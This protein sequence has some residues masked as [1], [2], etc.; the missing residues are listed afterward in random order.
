VTKDSDA[1]AAGARQML[2]RNA[3]PEQLVL[4]IKVRDG[5]DFELIYTLLCQ[6]T[7]KK[8]NEVTIVFAM[9]EE[10]RRRARLSARFRRLTPRGILLSDVFLREQY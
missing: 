8:P 5:R 2:I 6:N 3:C 1:V 4:R 10:E 7:S 9:P